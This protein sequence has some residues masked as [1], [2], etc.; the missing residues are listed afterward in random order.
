MDFKLIK[1]AFLYL[2]VFILLT[3]G[4][5]LRSSHPD[6]SILLV[7]SQESNSS[8]WPVVTAGSNVVMLL[9]KYYYDIRHFVILP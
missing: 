3:N 7:F 4:M 2:W 5:R 1:I 8:Y 6:L 9:K